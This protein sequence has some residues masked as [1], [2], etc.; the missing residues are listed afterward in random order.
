MRGIYCFIFLCCFMP[1]LLM[2]SGPFTDPMFNAISANRIDLVRGLL[3]D[4]CNLTTTGRDGM[5]PLDYA[6][7]ECRYEIAKLL[8]EHKAP[9]NRANRDGVYPIQFVTAAIGNDSAVERREDI[10]NIIQLLA[11]YGADVNVLDYHGNCALYYAINCAYVRHI[12]GKGPFDTEFAE[13]LIEN[14][15]R[16]DLVIPSWCKEGLEAFVRQQRASC[17]YHHFTIADLGTLQADS[18]AAYSINDHGVVC[19]SFDV[20]ERSFFFLWSPYKGLSMLSDLPATARPIKLNNRGQIAGNYVNSAGHNR[21]FFWDPKLGFMDIGTLG[22]ESTTV[23]AM[24][25]RGDVVGVSDRT[26]KSIYDKSINEKQAFTWKHGKAIS[27]LSTLTS[28]LGLSGDLSVAMSINDL[29]EVVGYSNSGTLH[30]GK[31]IRLAARPFHWRSSNMAQI[32][33]LETSPAVAV[34]AVA[35][36]NFSEI[37]LTIEDKS[38]IVELA[39]G[40]SHDLGNEGLDPPGGLTNSGLVYGPHWLTSPRGVQN[41]YGEPVDLVSPVVDLGDHWIEFQEIADI[42][43]HGVVVGRAKNEFGETQAVLLQPK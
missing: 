26:V 18:S 37:L 21:G 19:G 32:P 10:L 4:G 31:L 12:C 22:G 13:L 9:V 28:E 6:V 14:G 17:I 5:R 35:I 7:A 42:N 24:N 23:T 1:V 27:D 29:G 20:G 38:L 43:R 33:I 30:K 2:A 25:N 15:A 16:L 34:R 11:D 39:S 36:N 41:G 40:N 3:K 8:V